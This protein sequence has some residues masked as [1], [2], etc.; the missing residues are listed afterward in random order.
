MSNKTNNVSVAANV[1]EK[2]NVK[3]KTNKKID[4]KVMH[5]I[6][7]E[8]I[9]RVTHTKKGYTINPEAKGD[10]FMVGI[11]SANPLSVRFSR[12]RVST[13]MLDQHL[14]KDYTSSARIDKSTGVTSLVSFHEEVMTDTDQ[15]VFEMKGVSA[16]SAIL[17]DEYGGGQFMHAV[18]T[19][20]PGFFNCSLE[21][22]LGYSMAL[23]SGARSISQSRK[24]DILFIKEDKS[25]V[26]Y[27]EVELKF[28]LRAW[29][30]WDGKQYIIPSKIVN[31]FK[32]SASSGKA[33]PAFEDFKY[34]SKEETSFEGFK[35]DKV[36]GMIYHFVDSGN[37]KRS[38]LIVNE[39]FEV[40][41]AQLVK[42]A[43]YNAD[44]S[45]EMLEKEMEFIK[46]ATDGSMYIDMN[47]AHSIGMSKDI[48]V[49]V[50][51]TVKGM[52]NLVD[53]L[54]GDLGVTSVFFGGAVKGDPLAYFQD[55]IE[56]FILG[57]AADEREPEKDNWLLSNQLVRALATRAPETL[58][59]FESQSK[60]ILERAYNKDRLA[61]D[62]FL[63]LDKSSSEDEEE[64]SILDSEN[65]TAEAYMANPDASEKSDMLSKRLSDLIRKPAQDVEYGKSYFSQDT[66]YRHMVSD[67]YEV[68]RH[69]TLG[70]M[71]I[72][73]TA[74]DADMKGIA[75]DHVVS[76]QV[77]N[78]KFSIDRRKAILG[79]FP[80]LHELEIQVVNEDENLFLDE[81]SEA[82][83]AQLIAKGEHQ[84][85]LYYSLYD[86]VAE[87]QSNADYD[88]DRTTVI[89]FT[90]VTSLIS[91]TS[92]YLDYSSL[93]G[94]MVKGVPWKEDIVVTLEGA[95]KKG[96]IKYL[97]SNGVVYENG[98][99]TVDTLDMNRNV[100]ELL[101]K[102]LLNLDTSNNERNNIGVFTNF[103]ATVL[104]L[105]QL[106]RDKREEI[107]SSPHS[108]TRTLA[109]DLINREIA[110]YEKLNF[111][112][113]SAIRWE[114]DK[115]KHG[116]QFYKELPFLD[117][118]ADHGSI[119]V[120]IARDSEAEYGISMER[121]VLGFD[122]ESDKL[123]RALSSMDISPIDIEEGDKRIRISNSLNLGKGIDKG[124]VMNSRFD[125]YI[126]EM[127]VLSDTYTKDIFINESRRGLVDEATNYVN[128]MAE[129]GIV[130]EI[131]SSYNARQAFLEGKEINNA[132]RLLASYREKLSEIQT[133]ITEMEKRYISELEESAGGELIHSNNL[134]LETIMKKARVSGEERDKGYALLARKELLVSQHKGVGEAFT[135]ESP[136]ESA[137]LFAMLYLE[138]TRSKVKS[139]EEAYKDI[140][141]SG[142]IRKELRDKLNKAWVQKH[143]DKMPDAETK[144]N[145]AQW[146][147]DN[148]YEQVQSDS[149]W[150]SILTL[151]PLSTIQFLEFI[152]DERI[153]TVSAKGIN[154]IIYLEA[155]DGSM[156]PQAIAEAL[157]QLE[158][159]EITV[160][161]GIWSKFRLAVDDIAGRNRSTNASPKEMAHLQDVSRFEEIKGMQFERGS[162]LWSRVR[163]GKVLFSVAY[164]EGIK[165]FLEDS[166][167]VS[168]LDN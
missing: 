74:E 56:T 91:P 135:P 132:S 38:I 6:K 128:M 53:G 142:P 31:R 58:A 151:F 80:L 25:I 127:K 37:K 167:E 134:G 109:L 122:Q 83:Y 124:T 66:S 93:D 35:G 39:D 157:P 22:F 117:A 140:E 29:A 77:Q 47:Y 98:Y 19:D 64:E 43:Q 82:R 143:G 78:G 42:A 23:K 164:K 33:H 161:H 148:V 126:K 72:D 168:S 87:A 163:K 28:N 7:S 97:E 136:E 71:A 125:E 96:E 70:R 90:P 152:K 121:L 76:S 68:V 84:G 104:E 48:Q 79:R 146:I 63:G 138:N 115:S 105:I 54:L 137:L 81:A 158:G 10:S 14:P 3:M 112:M 27:L 108:E 45:I 16:T 89:R 26:D 46:P 160:D 107:L 55:R 162:H 131:E 88:G 44:G 153:K 51:P 50:G 106:L 57:E 99:F 20:A 61:L 114:I 67:P 65:L 149:G 85:M 32:L 49:R 8:N 101:Y 34:V 15:I 17:V 21:E 1:N 4:S 130:M 156:I 166:K 69:M 118:I 92:K 141:K 86:M 52:I 41:L 139:R 116:G 73:T 103:N 30:K 133:K 102:G 95:L 145:V 165:I 11:A 144:K 100:K 94:K 5:I 159:K 60:D 119:A 154:T 18:N 2:E 24:G 62:V 75:P 129:K 12:T 13:G 110:G 150:G 111:L 147:E 59:V 9:Y 40:K 36:D 155:I 123:N 120:Q 113:A